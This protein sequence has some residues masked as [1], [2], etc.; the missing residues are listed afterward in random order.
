MKKKMMIF[1]HRKESISALR[2]DGGDDNNNDDDNDDVDDD[3][4]DDDSNEQ[5]LG[6]AH[7]RNWKRW[8]HELLYEGCD[9]PYRR[10]GSC[11]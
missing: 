6:D 9:S 4:D 1:P 3:V 10:A 5:R 8:F 7:R 2:Y 11:C